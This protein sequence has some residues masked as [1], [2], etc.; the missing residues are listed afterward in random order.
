MEAHA[1][2][3]Q[4]TSERGDRTGGKKHP[5]T[6]AEPSPEVSTAS[7][8]LLITLSKA[9]QALCG[10]FSL[11]DYNQVSRRQRKQGW[12][13]GFLFR[14]IP[15]SEKL[16]IWLF[17]R[18]AWT[19]REELSHSPEE[20]NRPLLPKGGTC[21]RFEGCIFV[22][23][24]F[25]VSV[26]WPVGIT[27]APGTQQGSECD[28]GFFMGPDSQELEPEV[29]CIVYCLYF[30]QFLTREILLPNITAS[31]FHLSK[32]YWFSSSWSGISCI[33]PAVIL[34]WFIPQIFMGWEIGALHGGLEVKPAG[35]GDYWKI[36]A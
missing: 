31:P 7:W 35:H 3:L 11:S 22:L 24:G 12:T 21:P 26:V 30:S 8:I 36:R 29:P 19:W 6:V 34:I 15:I 18:L 17:P 13:M 14:F 10:N 4:V 2:V 27:P 20:K 33:T 16:Y 28:D 9:L 32:P 23:D 5:G 1:R 25:V